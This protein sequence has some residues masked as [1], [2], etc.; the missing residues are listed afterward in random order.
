M[1]DTMTITRANIAQ[2][3]VDRLGFN[4]YEAN[5]FVRL[6]FREIVNSLREGKDVRISS[7]GNFMLRDKKQRFGRNPRTGETAV[8]AARRVVIFKPGH[9][10]KSRVASNDGRNRKDTE[11]PADT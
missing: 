2:Y 10:L 6:L 11:S 4:K 5:E 9:K 1:V 7:F 3:L 8:I